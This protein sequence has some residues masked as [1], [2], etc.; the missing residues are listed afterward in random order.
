MTT[1]SLSFSANRFRSSITIANARAC[2]IFMSVSN[3]AVRLLGNRLLVDE[4]NEKG[5]THTNTKFRMRNLKS[6][7]VAEMIVIICDLNE[8]HLL[9][10][11]S[12]HSFIHHRRFA[13]EAAHHFFFSFLF[14]CVHDP[15]PAHNRYFR[16]IYRKITVKSLSTRAVLAITTKINELFFFH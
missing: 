14:R 10:K 12:E 5:M 2:F 13:T 15:R 16:M 7:N 3:L 6:S 11:K 9:T 8:Q 4:R 1:F